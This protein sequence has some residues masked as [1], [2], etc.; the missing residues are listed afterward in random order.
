MDTVIPSSNIGQRQK[1]RPAEPVLLQESNHLLCHLIVF[2]DHVLERSAQSNLNGGLI[3]FVKLHDV[4]HHANDARIIF[5]L[6]HDV[7]D[8]LIVSFIALRKSCQRLITGTGPQEILIL[9][10]ESRIQPLLLPGKHPFLF[11]QGFQRL[12][13]LIIFFLGLLQRSFQ[14]G[15][16]S[17]IFFQIRLKGNEPAVIFR[18]PDQKL[19]LHGIITA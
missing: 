16:L 17:V 4:S 1:S 5:L 14:P 8:G 10:L 12:Q 19:L 13:S 11:L 18:I 3:F 9:L 15:G 6:L 7:L 2:G